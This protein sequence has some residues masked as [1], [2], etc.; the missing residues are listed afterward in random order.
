MGAPCCGGLRGVFS[1][2]WEWYE[3][4]DPDGCGL[5]FFD[6][7]QSDIFSAAALNKVVSGKALRGFFGGII[8]RGEGH[9]K[10]LTG[11]IILLRSETPTQ[12]TIGQ[13]NESLLNT[14]V[15]ES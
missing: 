10:P 3:P 2:R 6:L 4:V 1:R 13:G 8:L 11:R 5:V 12:N 15:A 9:T 7:A 14:I